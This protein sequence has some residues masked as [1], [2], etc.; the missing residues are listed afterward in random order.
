MNLPALDFEMAVV[1][2]L[3]QGQSASISIEG[4]RVGSIGRLA[5]TI[6]AL[7]ISPACL[8]R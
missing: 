1:K 5:E 2:H 8:R 6:A 7:R 4:V 3:R